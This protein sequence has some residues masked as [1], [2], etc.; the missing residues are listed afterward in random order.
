MLECTQTQGIATV[1]RPLIERQ[2]RLCT[3]DGRCTNRYYVVEAHSVA[4]SISHQSLRVV[5]LVLVNDKERGSQAHS[6]TLST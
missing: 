2:Q 3:Q 1:G 6:V 4:I 5:I